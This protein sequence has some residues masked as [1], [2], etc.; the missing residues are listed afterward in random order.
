MGAECLRCQ[1]GDRMV[2]QL[3]MQSL[4]KNQSSGKEE[5]KQQTRTGINNLRYLYMP[6]VV[7][8]GVLVSI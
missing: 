8:S 1:E 7:D 2:L 6:F 5:K 4:L 3:E